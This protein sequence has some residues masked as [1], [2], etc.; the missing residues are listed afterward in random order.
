MDKPVWLRKKSD[1]Q[2]SRNSFRNC[3]SNNCCTKTVIVWP[4]TTIIALAFTI[5]ETLNTSNIYYTV[6][7]L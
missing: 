1:Q 3:A 5:K 7:W 2:S 4:F 6:Q